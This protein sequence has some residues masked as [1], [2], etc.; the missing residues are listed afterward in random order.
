MRWFQLVRS[1][2]VSG[3]SGIGVV[4]DGV[5]FPDGTVVLWWWNYGSLGIF[6]DIDLL[7]KIHG[8]DGRTTVQWAGEGHRSADARD[9]AKRLG[10]NPNA[11]GP[12]T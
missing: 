12:A 10:R 3:V 11:R 6:R 5:Q 1:E 2:D 7:T 9:V 4:A 8:H